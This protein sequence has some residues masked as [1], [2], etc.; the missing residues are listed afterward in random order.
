MTDDMFKIGKF[1]GT[2]RLDFH[3]YKRSFMAVAMIKGFD[4]ALERLLNVSNPMAMSYEDNMRKRKMAWSYLTLT[5]VGIPA[6]IVKRT[7]SGDPCD[8]WAAL[9][10]KYEPNTVEAFNQI[11]R[12]MEMCKLEE[13]EQDPESWLQQ[14]D[15]YN[16]RLQSIGGSTANYGK[17]DVQMIQHILSKLPKKIYRPFTTA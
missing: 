11:T 5:L 14:L 3:T 1:D 8:A 4:E 17:N 13:S 7:T 16:A 9:C 2:T 10:N 15:R 6:A 12:D